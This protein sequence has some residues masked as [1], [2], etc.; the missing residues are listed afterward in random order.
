MKLAETTNLDRK[1]GERGA[2]VRRVGLCF[3]RHLPSLLQP[4]FVVSGHPTPLINKISLTGST[5]RQ[6]GQLCLKK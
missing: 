2:P 1:S 6:F 4:G 5:G 3:I